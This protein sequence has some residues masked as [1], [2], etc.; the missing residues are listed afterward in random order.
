MLVLT[1]PHQSRNKVPQQT[2][3]LSFV[4]LLAILFDSMLPIMSYYF[5]RP[6]QYGPYTLPFLE[7]FLDPE[8]SGGVRIDREA[9]TLKVGGDE[10]NVGI[11][12]SAGK[13]C[14]HEVVG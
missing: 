9:P 10:G 2:V 1:K 6:E 7:L 3:H 12:R 14:V 11:V 4:S 13:G 5:P 8:R